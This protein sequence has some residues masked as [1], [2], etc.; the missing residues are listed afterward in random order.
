MPTN[1]QKN[2]IR[3]NSKPW[4]YMAVLVL[5]TSAFCI[6][7]HLTTI[8]L[9]AQSEIHSNSV[10]EN[11]LGENRL[12]L[13]RWLYNKADQYFHRGV[14]GKCPKCLNN[15][16]FQR[17]DN[18]LSPNKHVHIEG[19]DA[20]EM[21]P[22]L[23]L[24]LDMNPRDIQTHL[25]SAFWL[26]N[27][28]E[29]PDLAHKILRKAQWNNP[30]CYHVQLEIAR[31][32]LKEKNFHDAK[33]SLDAG[34]AFISRDSVPSNEDTHL[35]K[36]ALLL[37][38]SL[39]YEQDGEN[40]KAISGMEQILHIFPNRTHLN[41]RIQELRKGKQPSV[42]P[43]KLWNAILEHEQKSRSTCNNP[44]HNHEHKH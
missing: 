8:P 33:R 23:Q 1:C 36:A 41:A 32:Y 18:A 29:R 34:I 37:Y 17:I 38:R 11:L 21:L 7:S 24:A 28:C 13:N 14:S 43:S 39:L 44:E 12:L 3:K 42:L 4:P 30:F 16:P 25:I 31:L 27:K 2:K 20:A 10:G 40:D 9:T 22:W 5:W 6:A 19:P 15:S 35:A 26:A